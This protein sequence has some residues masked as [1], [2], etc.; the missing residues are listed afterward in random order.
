[1]KKKG[2][3][4]TSKSPNLQP[5]LEERKA[6]DAELNDTENNQIRQKLSKVNAEIKIMYA[7][8]KRNKWNDL[9]SSLN[10]GSSNGKLWRLVKSMGEEQPQ[11]EKCNTIKSNDGKI[12]QNDIEAANLLGSHYQ[13]ISKLDFT[14]KDRHIKHKASSIVHGCRSSPLDSSTI[15]SRAFSM[16]ELN[17]AINESSLNKSPGPDGVHGQMISNLRLPGRVRCLN[18][19]N[20]SWNSGKLPRELRRAT[21]VPVRKPSKEASSPESYRPIALTCI[22]CKI[23]EKR[24]LKRLNFY[25]NSHDLLPREQFGFREGH[26]TTDQVLYICQRVRDA[27]KSHY[28]SLL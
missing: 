14:R 3:F 13:S 22:A 25:L 9:C 21:V 20:D 10:T 28:G 2:P 7:Q 11:M 24:I 26:S 8:I 19:I 4:L 23:M 5:L 27:H 16:Q 17:T 18:I 6:L 15:F 1:M 12:P